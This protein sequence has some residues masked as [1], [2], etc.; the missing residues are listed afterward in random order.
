M[1]SVSQSEN[2]R[3]RRSQVLLTAALEMGD[4]SL[5]VT[6]RNL[7]HDGALVQGAD[8]P[9]ETESLV[10]HRQGLSVPGK[11]AWVHGQFAGIAFEFPLSPSDLLRHIPAPERRL[12][13]PPVKRRPGFASVPLTPAERMLIERW[14]TESATRLGE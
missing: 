13:P 2:R 10:F 8:L 4:V 7:S 3:H 1:G 9:A 6:L 12:A 14:A 11:V 5:P